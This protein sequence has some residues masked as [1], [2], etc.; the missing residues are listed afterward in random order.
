MVLA[1][2][3]KGI[4]HESARLGVLNLIPKPGK[5]TRHIK[6]L[7]PITL[8]NVD[9]KVIEK[10]IANKMIPALV[11]IIHCDQRGFMKNR[12]ISVNIRKLLDIM[13][14]AKQNDIEALILSLDFVKC[15]DKCSFSI[16]HGSLEFFSFGEIVKKWTYI[17]YKKFQVMIQNNGNFSNRIDINKGVHQGGC[18]SS[19]Y[20]LVIAEILA[21]ALRSNDKITGITVAQ[22]RNILN[23]FADDADVF[24]LNSE[25]SLNQ[26][27]SELEKFRLQSGFT[28]SYD[29]TTLYR[30]GSLRHSCVKMYDISHVK[31]SNDDINV[32]GITIAHDNLV[33][34]NYDNIQKKV[35]NTLNAW[36]NRGLSLMGKVLVVNTL[37]ASL[38]VYKM[39]VLPMMPDNIIK[40]IENEIRRF[41]WNGKSAKIAFQVLKNPYD[42][43]GLKLVDLKA[44][45]KALKATW[46]QILLDEK[47]YSVMVYSVLCPELH[48][49]IWKVYLRPEHVKLFN[50]SNQFWSDVLAAWCEYN[51]WH[52]FQIDNQIIWYNS[53]ILVENKP[54]LWKKLLRNGLIYIYQLFRDGKYKSFHQLNTEYGISIMQYN[55]LTM[56]L[57]VDWKVYM[58]ELTQKSFLPLLPCNYDIDCRL[59]NLSRKIYQ[60]LNG[61]IMLIHTK[62]V[63]WNQ[64]LGTEWDLFEF[65]KLIGMVRRF[66]NYTKIRDFQYRFLQRAIITNIQLLRWKVIDSDLCTICGKEQETIQHLF[67]NCEVITKLWEMFRNYYQ[68]EY[69]TQVCIN[70]LSI[71]TGYVTEP[72]GHVINAISVYLKQFIYRHRCQKQVNK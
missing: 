13:E 59:P 12:R 45:D 11:K 30:I 10:A 36:E 57:P 34:K 67:Y 69:N 3:D 25:E 9:Y 68:L 46:P 35:F 4:L 33:M 29:K 60:C 6:N 54:I 49:L 61:D 66:T 62:M 20:F 44:K 17:L 50:I 37:V 40:N 27:L 71:V 5:D 47:D 22:I 51:Y 32:L 48:E 72:K 23:Q 7:R 1:V 8:L 42:Q 39:M 26:I 16:L 31:W 52:N 18:C 19:V 14:Y 70:W 43:G 41:L 55:S 38:F 58:C 56:A 2:Y 53:R 65:G 21:I 24:S 15:F 63:K 64:E 28:I